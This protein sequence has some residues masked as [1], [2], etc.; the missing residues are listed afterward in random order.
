MRW[1]GT[2]RLTWRDL[3][4]IVKQCKSGDAIYHAIHSDEPYPEDLSAAVYG[5]TQSLE[6][7]QRLLVWSKTKDA[8]HGRNQPEPVYFPWDEKPQRDG[9]YVADPMTLQEALDFAGWSSEM[10]EHLRGGV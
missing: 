9:A 7:H 5:L 4:V 2:E 1:L 3:L 10:N 6:Y 8:K